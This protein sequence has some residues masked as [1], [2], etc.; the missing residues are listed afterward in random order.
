VAPGEGSLLYQVPRLRGGPGKVKKGQDERG[1]AVRKVESAKKPTKVQQ[2]KKR[3]IEQGITKEPD[4]GN[5]P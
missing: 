4:S 5:Q 2:K 1:W 3:K